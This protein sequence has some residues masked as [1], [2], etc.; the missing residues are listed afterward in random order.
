MKKMKKLLSMLLAVV[1]VLAMAAPSFADSVS[2]KDTGKITIDNA[3]AGKTYKAWKIFDVTYSGENYAYSIKN[4]NSALLTL[5]TAYATNNNG[6]TLTKSADELTYVVEIKDNVFKAADFAKYLSENEEKLG[7]V[8]NL[9][10]SNG[11]AEISK[12]PLGYYFVKTN[13]GAL[14]NL[15]TTNPTA[16]IHDKNDVPFDKDIVETNPSVQVGQEVHFTLKGKVPDTTGLDNYLYKFTDTMSKGLKL[17]K[18]SVKIRIGNA[19]E[20]TPTEIATQ[21]ESWTTKTDDEGNEIK[22]LHYTSQGDKIL[23]NDNLENNRT[24]FMLYI[25]V[26]ALNGTPS[27]I[28]KEILVTYS[29]IVTDDAV[30]VISDNTATLTYKNDYGINEDSVKTTPED[31]VEIYSSKIVIDKYTNTDEKDS[32]GN[33]IR[34]PLANAEFVLFR[35]GI[36]GN[37][38]SEGNEEDAN[39]NY[40]YKYIA[41]VD[42]KPAEGDQPAVE[43]QPAKVVWVKEDT[44]KALPETERYEENVYVKKTDDEG[45]TSFD[46]LQVLPEGQFYYVLET[47]APAGYNLL[48]DAKEVTLQK[49]DWDVNKKDNLLQNKLLDNNRTTEETTT[50]LTSTTE[51]E[52]VAGALLPST[53]GIGTT[54]FYAAGIILMAGAVFF[55]VRRKRA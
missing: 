3:E 51:V 41:A 44:W 54:I 26:N 55:V 45:A 20:T 32:A 12:L 43:A 13:T 21:L 36:A 18:N 17:V 48:K 28:G 52:N 50:Y 5:I 53:G 4:D 34:Q 40:Y 33:P 30:T 15:T 7:T 49:L 24:G 42:A 16:N 39:L 38:D 47:K 23:Y 6:L 37:K 8:I 29:A 25:D 10:N 11:T 9:N 14:C 27:N 19:T 31:K 2:D 46:C 1:M 35:K 22:E